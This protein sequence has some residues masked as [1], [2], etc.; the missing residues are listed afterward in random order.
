MTSDTAVPLYWALAFIVAASIPQ[1]SIL[2]SFV[3]AAFILQ[4]SFTFP[5]ILMVAYNVQ[6]D[7]MLDS[8]PFDPVSGQA[9]RSDHGMARW[10]RGYK[11]KLFSNTFNVIYFV[12]SLSVAGLGIYASVLGMHESFATTVL[13]PFTC[14]SPT[15]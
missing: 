6:K 1:I 14:G 2:A 10:I 8:E 9:Q 11:Q 13:T 12:A 4:F 3:G 15:G 5:P 7:A